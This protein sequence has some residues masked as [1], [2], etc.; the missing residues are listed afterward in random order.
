MLSLPATLRSVRS[1]KG[2]S[3]AAPGSKKGKGTERG[4]EY[5]KEKIIQSRE[6]QPSDDRPHPDAAPSGQQRMSSSEGNTGR[7]IFLDRGELDN[8]DNLEGL[9]STGEQQSMWDKQVLE[10]RHSADG[11]LCGIML[12]MGPCFGTHGIKMVD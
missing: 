3:K 10:W 4:L 2:K 6:Q 9:M 11:D 8:L 1:G 7:T 5:W 12:I